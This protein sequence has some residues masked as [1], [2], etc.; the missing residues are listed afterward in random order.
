[1]VTIIVFL[2][3]LSLLVIVHEFGHFIVGRKAGIGVLEFALGLPFTKPLWSRKV[4]SGMRISLY[5]VL[6]GGFVKLL[7]E[8]GE[9]EHAHEKGEKGVAGKHFYKA[10]V[11]TRIA[12]VVAGV[13]M[14]F[15]LAIGAFYL[16]LGLSN[17]RV[18]IPKFVEYEFISPSETRVV[19][20]EVLPDSPAKMAGLGFGDVLLAVDGE[21]ITSAEQFRKV[22]REKGGQEVAIEVASSDLSETRTVRLTPR[23]NPAEN[24]GAVG[25]RI[26]EARLIRFESPTEKI[27]SGVTFAADMVAY[28]LKV[29]SHFAFSAFQTGDTRVVSESV[30]GP[31]GIAKIVDDILKLPFFE[32]VKTLINF[33]GLL[34]LSLAVMNIMPIPAMDGGRLAFLLVEAIFGKRLAIEKEN[35][36][37]QVGMIILLGLIILISFNDIAKIIAR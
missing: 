3:I 19:A 18:L 7:G 20:F 1:M 30:S 6:F 25:V 31:I 36:I 8:E 24:Q 27:T 37:N 22:G 10:G 2:L 34:S 32:A 4:R 16:F 11:W 9:E 13:A 5:P 28:N 29:I 35:L 15:L 26:D 14:N 17:F 23:I 12:I 21:R 33:V